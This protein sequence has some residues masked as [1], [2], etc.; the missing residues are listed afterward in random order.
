MTRSRTLSAAARPSCRTSFILATMAVIAFFMLS[1]IAHAAD[2]KDRGLSDEDM[3]CLKCHAKPDLEKTL[4]NGKKLSLYIGTKTFAG[5]VHGKEGC[6]GC[7]AEIDAKTHGKEKTSLESKREL[8]LSMMETCRDCH[9]KTVKQY[10]DSVHAALVQEGSK[11]APLCSDCHDPHATQSSKDAPA[12]T[13]TVICQKCHESIDKAYTASVHG[14]AGDDALVCADCHHTH[15]VKAASLGDNMKK[16]CIS[17]HRDTATT[18]ATWLPNT[19]RHLEAISC[20]ACHSPGAKRRVNLRLYDGMTQQQASDKVGVP[21]FIKLAPGADANAAGLDSRALWSMLQDFNRD[22][23]KEKT[24]LR[25]RLE[26]RTGIE[27]HQLAKK[28]QA[29]KDCDTCHSEGAES[30]QSVTI[31]IAGPDGRPLRR[32][33]GKGVLNSIESIES[34]SGF[35]AL[36]STRIKLLDTLLAL[37]VAAGIFLPGAHLTAK[38]LSRRARNKQ[39]AAKDSSE[40]SRPDSDMLN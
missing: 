16:E 22:G 9:K 13:D 28:E 12:H 4:G 33:A 20:P 37:T 21:Q 15:N 35:Y 18:H 40:T 8:S 25:G 11:K 27:A 14:Q 30:F 39:E 38:W 6:E 23:A 31:S 26:V 5:S 34:V 24:V 10:E 3:A 32:D 2:D 1:M 17:C 36:G 7:H 29:L 19:Q